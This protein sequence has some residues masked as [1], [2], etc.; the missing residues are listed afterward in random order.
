MAGI[1][2]EALRVLMEK[3]GAT[4]V[5]LAPRVG[6][7]RQYLGDILAGRRTLKRNPELVNRL[8]HALNVPR[9]MIERRTTEPVG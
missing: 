2:G 5:G 4:V 1:D 3:D 6:I 8:A 9:S 7:S